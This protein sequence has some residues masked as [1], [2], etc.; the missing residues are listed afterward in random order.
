LHGALLSSFVA[1]LL[2]LASSEARAQIVNVQPLVAESPRE[3]ASGALEASSDWRSGNTNLFLVSGSLIGRYRT[4]RHLVFGLL[5]GEY[6][7]QTGVAFVSKDTEH[8]RYR[9]VASG[10]I[11]LETY[12]QHERDE[13]R[14][15][16]LRGLAGFGPR[17]HVS[18]YERMDAAIGVAYMFEYQRLAEDGKPDA[19]EQQYNHRLSSYLSFMVSTSDRVHVG[20][21]FYVQPRFDAWSDYR[22]LSDTEFV[23]SATKL[24]AFKVSSAIAFDSRPPASVQSLDITRKASIEVHF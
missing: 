3:G 9:V 14:R 15:V 8:L 5:K 10:P 20:E 4:G 13:F 22:I 11:E 21:T 17:L 24:L 2:V 7:A 19:G 16:A 1:A 18:H 6:G 12:V 23:L